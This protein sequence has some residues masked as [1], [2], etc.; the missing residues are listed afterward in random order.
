MT[1]RTVDVLFAILGLLVTAPLFAV[2]ALAI[3]LDS[4]GRLIFS[5][6][7]LGKNGKPFWLHKFRKFPDTWGN[8]GPGVTVA[9]DARMTRTGR[10]LE[11]TKLDELPQL[12]NILRG[13]MSF[14]GPRPE[15]LR[16]ADLFRGELAEVLEYLPGIF[17]PN[18]IAFRN[19][20]EMYPPDQDPEVFYAAILFP[21]KAKADI[22]Y[23]RN[24]SVFSDLS[25]IA[26]GVWVSLVGVIDW[27]RTIGLHGPILAFDLLA[28]ETAW[29]LANLVRFEGLPTPNNWPVFVTGLWLLPAV[30]LP[31]MILAGVYRHPVRYFALIDALRLVFSSMIGWT[32]AYLILV[33][34]LHRNA[35]F[36]LAPFGFLITL[37]LI[38][39]TRLWRREWWRKTAPDRQHD[40]HVRIVVYGAGRRGNALVSFLEHGF[41]YAKVLGFL[42]DN[43]AFLRGRVILGYRILGSERDLNTVHAVH[44]MDQL[45]TTFE[46]DTH[47]HRR[48]QHWCQANAVKLVVVPTTAP[49]SAL[50]CPVPELLFSDSDERANS[51]HRQS[52]LAD[53]TVA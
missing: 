41:G 53:R 49:F 10:F 17:G 8:A 43:D 47:K 25:W 26:R 13:E 2:I 36:F 21:R 32:L 37:S 40:Q 27:R 1:K 39:T 42:D 45:W 35:S 29:L 7:R 20:S 14:V 30:L 28:I 18:Q 9:G 15:S 44:A 4:P 22:D 50:C 11:R 3:K 51:A 48:L 52:G 5:Q 19:E 38:G 46:P 23:F 34:L 33:G 6:R 24:A 12:L 16:Y 31:L